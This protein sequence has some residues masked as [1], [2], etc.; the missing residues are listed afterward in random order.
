MV[1][2]YG[3]C[4]KGSVSYG[5]RMYPCEVILLE[6]KK[7]RRQCSISKRENVWE[8]WARSRGQYNDLAQLSE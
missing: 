7:K 6:L 4:D 1:E 3:E 2:A 5:F 8:S